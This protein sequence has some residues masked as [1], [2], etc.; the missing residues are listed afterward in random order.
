MERTT[1][2][3]ANFNPGD[4]VKILAAGHEFYNA[5]ATVIE[6]LSGYTYPVYRLEHH[7]HPFYWWM[8]E[9]VEDA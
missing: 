5:R 7:I 4:R 8:L 3:P 2:F 6:R 1:Y 9:K